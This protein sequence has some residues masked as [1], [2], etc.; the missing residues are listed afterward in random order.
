MSTETDATRPQVY[1]I[2]IRTTPQA[3]WERDSTRPEFT[4]R[5][6]HGA[7]VE[8]KGEV[9]TPIRYHSPDG[10]ALW[11]DETVLRPSPAAVWSSGGARCTTRRSPP[12]ST[13]RVTW[14]ITEQDGG[15]CLLAVV[16]DHLEGAPLTARSVGGAGWMMVL[17]GL[18]TLLETGEPLVR[19]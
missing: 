4:A 18:K 9:G 11:G 6:F 17:S 16:H 3:L 5:Y 14:E 2:F 19:R 1:Q 15:Y 7:R 12:S 10:S 8:T 13:S